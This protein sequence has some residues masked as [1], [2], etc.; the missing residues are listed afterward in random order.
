VAEQVAWLHIALGDSE[1]PLGMIQGVALPTMRGDFPTGLQDD[2][3]IAN[4]T[5]FDLIERVG[6]GHASRIA[7]CVAPREAASAAW[8]G[9]ATP[10]TSNDLAARFAAAMTGGAQAANSASVSVPGHSTARP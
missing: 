10:Y 7:Q 9:E 5:D 6:H 3:V 1:E 4:Q 2:P 8:A